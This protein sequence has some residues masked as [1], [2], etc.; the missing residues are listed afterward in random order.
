MV[1]HLDGAYHQSPR[2]VVPHPAVLN[3]HS[4]QDKVLCNICSTSKFETEMGLKALM[5]ITAIY[6]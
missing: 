2:L 1:V 4:V 5:T 3:I 6:S